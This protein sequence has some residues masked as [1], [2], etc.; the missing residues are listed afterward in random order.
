M[1]SDVSASSN[2]DTINGD[3]NDGGYDAEDAIQEDGIINLYD[4]VPDG[5]PALLKCAM[6]KKDK[7][8]LIRYTPHGS[9]VAKWY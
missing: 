6:N 3:V 4:L 1:L 8:V 7:V 5:M 2:Y 9:E